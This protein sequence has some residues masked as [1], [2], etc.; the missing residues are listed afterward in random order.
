[1]TAQG[2]RR[3]VGVH[4]GKKGIKG[5]PDQG[6]RTCKGHSGVTQSDIFGYLL[7]VQFC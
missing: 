1:M 5:T 4:F 7:S 3:Q 2:F 6:N